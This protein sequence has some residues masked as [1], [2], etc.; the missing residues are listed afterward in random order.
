MLPLSHLKSHEMKIFI[1]I[2]VAIDVHNFALNSTGKQERVSSH[3][4]GTLWIL[5]L[6][7]F[8]DSTFKDSYMGSVSEVFCFLF[9][10]L[11]N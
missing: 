10:C 3:R 7:F 5:L 8:K 6:I 1:D 9:V 11:F 4:S 2:D